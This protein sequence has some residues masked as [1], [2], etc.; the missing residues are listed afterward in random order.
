M[1]D[2]AE[3]PATYEISTLEDMARVYSE[4]P[5]D[6]GELLI[7]EIGDAVRMIAPAIALTAA[8][9]GGVSF[10]PIIW[11]NDTKGKGTI[12]V[13]TEDGDFN[14]TVKVDLPEAEA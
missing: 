9:G 1:T 10:L 7:K 4:L 3:A 6:R 13:S 2:T 8:L 11:I 12:N 14:A 5:H